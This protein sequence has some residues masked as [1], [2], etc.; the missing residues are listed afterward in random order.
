MLFMSGNGNE[1]NETVGAEGF[2]Q[3]MGGDDQSAGRAAFMI[4]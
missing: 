2:W 1:M 4:Q 3:R